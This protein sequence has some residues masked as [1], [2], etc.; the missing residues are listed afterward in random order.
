MKE[1]QTSNPSEQSAKLSRLA[2]RVP[3]EAADSLGVSE[4]FF[5]QHIRP[6]LRLVR[7]GRLVFVSVAELQRWLERNSARA[8]ERE[9]V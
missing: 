7:R 8:L 3:K 2:M 5:D 4:D 9:T 1:Q 6:E